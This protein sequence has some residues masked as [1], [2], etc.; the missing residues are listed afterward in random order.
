MKSFKQYITEVERYESEGSPPGLPGL[1]PGDVETL[2][3]SPIEYPDLYGPNGIPW[4]PDY[5]DDK[6]KFQKWWKGRNAFEDEISIWR[7]FMRH[8]G[9]APAWLAPLLITQ[10]TGH[11]ADDIPTYPA[12][13]PPWH[14]S[15]PDNDWDNPPPGWFRVP[16]GPFSPW[17][18][19]YFPPPSVGGPWRWNGETG[20]WEKV[21]GDFVGPP[22][23]YETPQGINPGQLYPKP[24]DFSEDSRE[25]RPTTPT[26]PTVEP[27]DNI[28]WQQPGW[29]AP[30]GWID[31]PSWPPPPNWNPPSGFGWQQFPWFAVPG[32]PSWMRPPGGAWPPPPTW[33]PINPNKPT[34]R[35]PTMIPGVGRPYNNP[36]TPGRDPNW[37]IS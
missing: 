36:Y 11:G 25:N 14:G 4:E 17:H 6:E 9:R 33:S 21:P 27:F 29:Q 5:W 19:R 16:Q 8:F 32:A 23:T 35:N 18:Y 7:W 30:P 12:G 24:P 34:Y 10:E 15:H 2:T 37:L 26:T 28:P 20:I 13:D 1:T 3:N 22:E 31:P